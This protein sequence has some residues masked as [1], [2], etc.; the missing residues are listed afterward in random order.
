M[1][2]LRKFFYDFENPQNWID[3]LAKKSYTD[4][5]GDS[6]VRP[7]E[8]KKNEVLCELKISFFEIMQ[9]MK[10]IFAKVLN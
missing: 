6:D 7:T 2:K 4:Y 9:S 3:N 8:K 5:R 1:E 10:W